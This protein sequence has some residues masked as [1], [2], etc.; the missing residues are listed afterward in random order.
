MRGAG[1]KTYFT[2]KWHCRAKA[3]KAFDVARHVR[4]GMPKQTPEGYNRPLADGSDP[5]SPYDPKFGG[6]WEGGKHW[7]E[8]VGDDAV[9]FLDDAKGQDKPFFMYVAFNAPHDPRQSPR[10]Y[11]D[12]YPSNKIVMPKNFLPVY[13]HKDIASMGASLRDEKLA[14]FPRTEHAVQVNRQEY[15][16]IITHM[17]DQ[18]SRILKKLDESGQADNT[19][20]FFT[21]DHGLACGHHGLMGKQNM[22]DHSVR[23]PFMVVGP[24]VRKGQRVAGP[25]YLQ[26]AMATTLELAGIDKPEHV[27]F[28]SVLPMLDGKPSP[29]ESVYGAYL[30]AQR[31]IRT[32]QYKMILYPTGKVARLYNLLED[33][34]EMNDLADQPQSRPIMKGLFAKLLKHQEDLDDEL[35]LTKAFPELM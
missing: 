19:W 2:G 29:Y 1:Y 8:V 34:D 11:V 35:D 18:I 20:I 27:E 14:P 17:D 31:S 3:E 33:P 23:V 6:F 10:E 12:R 13:P 28:N 24:K 25:I 26:D 21:A 30:K 9:D 32:D 15:F 7:S 5:W 4:G 22:Y 16:A